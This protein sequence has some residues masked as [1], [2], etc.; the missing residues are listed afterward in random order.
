MYTFGNELEMFSMTPLKGA[1][2]TL[3]HILN[4]L[5]SVGILNILASERPK[6]YDPYVFL[7]NF[8]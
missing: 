7:Q 2:L 8:M 3:L 4:D 5:D 6:S 1:I